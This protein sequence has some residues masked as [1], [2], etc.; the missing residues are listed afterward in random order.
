MQK[1]NSKVVPKMD[2]KTVYDLH[3]GL[4]FKRTLQEHYCMYF[5]Y[6]KEAFRTRMKKNNFSQA[7]KDFLYAQL[8]ANASHITKNV[9]YEVMFGTSQL[10]LT[11][12]ETSC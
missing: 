6:S 5:D 11:E 12:N 4:D 7:E 8:K 3:L 9:P 2:F 10:E 1:N